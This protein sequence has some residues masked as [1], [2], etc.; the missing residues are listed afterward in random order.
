MPPPGFNGG[1]M[2]DSLGRTN[3]IDATFGT[4]RST[5]PRGGSKSDIGLA[6]QPGVDSLD[7]CK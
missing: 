5:T 6:K 3:H 7:W 1:A 2:P 4:Y